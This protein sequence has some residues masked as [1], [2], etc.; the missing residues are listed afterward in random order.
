M[1]KE[2]FTLNLLIISVNETRENQ[3]IDRVRFGISVPLR[4]NLAGCTTL[5]F[6]HSK[7]VNVLLVR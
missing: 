3:F 2:N 1:R 5:T 7:V 6:G 4:Y